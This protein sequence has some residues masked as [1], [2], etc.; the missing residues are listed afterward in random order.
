M[1]ALLL[2]ISLSLATSLLAQD[3]YK[4]D[5]YNVKAYNRSM[6]VLSLSLRSQ[7]QNGF[8]FIISYVNTLFSLEK[9]RPTQYALN[10]RYDNL[11]MSFSFKF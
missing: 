3:N 4:L 8:E 9:T 10:E 5:I 1:K 2:T 6:P 7:E 11:K